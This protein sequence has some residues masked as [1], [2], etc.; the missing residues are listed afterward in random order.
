MTLIGIVGFGN[1][2]RAIYE[3]AQS[4][5]HLE[6]A[7]VW[8]RSLD[9]LFDLPE[10]IMLEDLEDMDDMPL[11][12]SFSFLARVARLKPDFHK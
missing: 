9:K 12:V 11:K 5:P 10:E 7:W 8:N 3:Y 1:L 4:E 6:V 2:G